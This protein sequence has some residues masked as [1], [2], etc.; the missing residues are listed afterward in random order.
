[1]S[2]IPSVFV[3]CCSMHLHKI[4]FKFIYD[5]KRL[6]HQVNN[7]QAES[8]MYRVLVFR[9]KNSTF[10]A[11]WWI[12]FVFDGI[13]PVCLFVNSKYP[14]LSVPNFTEIF[15]INT[16]A[17]KLYHCSKTVHWLQIENKRS[18][19]T[20]E[21]NEKF[22]WNSSIAKVWIYIIASHFGFFSIFNSSHLS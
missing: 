2:E 14:I 5:C 8:Q 18:L 21:N 12:R 3:Y 17:R 9:W 1:M 16:I 6:K 22:S 7:K 11:L 10:F 13:E 19:E 4:C 15:A 20:L